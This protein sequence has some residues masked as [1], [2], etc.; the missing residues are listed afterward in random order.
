LL[1]RWCLRNFNQLPRALGRLWPGRYASNAATLMKLLNFGLDGNILTFEDQ[2]F[3]LHNDFLF[4]ELS[5]RVTDAELTLTWQNERY[6]LI[7][8]V[9]L[10]AFHLHFSGVHMLRVLGQ[11]IGE[12]AHDDATVAQIGF[13]WNDSEE[14]GV[15]VVGKSAQPLQSPI[16]S[17]SQMNISFQM[18]LTVKIGAEEAMC[19]LVP[20]DGQ[21]PPWSVTEA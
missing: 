19:Q 5:H 1:Q 17:A 18:D 21:N 8:G 15:A 13:M 20:P 6:G 7:E 16:E 2:Q 3:D 9:S 12:K 14:A 4:D 11:D 10:E